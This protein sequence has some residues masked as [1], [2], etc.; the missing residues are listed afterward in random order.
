MARRLLLL[1]IAV[2]ALGAF[3]AGVLAQ[4]FPLKQVTETLSR[5]PMRTERVKDNLY[6][7]RGPFVPCGPRG[8]TPN[9][10]DDGLIHEPGDVAVRV[11][12]VGVILIDDKFTENV[13]EVMT[14]LKTVTTQPV[15]YLLNTHH[16]ADHASGNSVI[17]NMGIDV[18]A[19]KNI[20]ANF[21]RIKQ[22]GEPNIVFADQ[23]AVYLGDVEVQLLYLGRGHTNGD[24]IIYFPDL[25]AV[26]TGDLIIDAMPVIDYDAGGSA[27]EFVKT[28]DNL[29]KIDF[30]TV[31]PGHGRVMN[32][33]DVRAYRRRFEELNRRMQELAA[34]KA[35]KDPAQLKSALKLEDLGWERSVST[36]AY[37]RNITRHYDEMSAAKGRRTP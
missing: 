28:I 6:V 3:A 13:A 5:G 33:D 35:S 8:C 24:T 37:M 18:I 34:K 11:T 1:G 22:P 25:K 12:P 29:L 20:R 36:I 23:A 16:H 27:I 14:Q 15:K 31:I 19:H 17:R 32:K 7:I 30:D 26:H 2:T 10:E 4:V 21:L 9:A